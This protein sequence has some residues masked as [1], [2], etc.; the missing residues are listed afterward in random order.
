MRT[1]CPGTDPM[2]EVKTVK[3]PT[4][5]EEAPSGTTCEELTTAPIPQPLDHLRG[6]GRKTRSEAAPGKKGGVEGNHRII[7]VVKD[8]QI[9]RAK[10]LTLH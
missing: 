9:Y 3:S 7:R 1:V 5:E 4:P 10:H 8:L 6:G 2:L